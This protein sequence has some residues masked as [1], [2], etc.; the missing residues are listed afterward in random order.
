MFV[1]SVFSPL[2][3]PTKNNCLFHILSVLCSPFISLSLSN[4][5]LILK[6][7]V[8]YFF[9]IF[10]Y[11]HFQMRISLNH[12][13][14]G[15]AHRELIKIQI[16][17]VF[18]QIVHSFCFC[19]SFFYIYLELFFMCFIHLILITFTPNNNNNNQLFIT[20]FLYHCVCLTNS[21]YLFAYFCI[22]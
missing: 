22:V 21:T 17:Q 5:I 6:F 3:P 1:Y 15:W 18:C 12:Y 19:L 10:N 14:F 9:F 4:P 13:F 11:T 7:D 8:F 16:H 2:L 20:Q